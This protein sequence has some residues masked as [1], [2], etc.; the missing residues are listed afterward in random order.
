MSAILKEKIAVLLSAYNGEM[1]IKEQL[2]SILK[3]KL[4]NVD[5][6]VYIRDDGSKD[7]T[8][9]ILRDY[10][11][12]NKNVHLI[13]GNNVGYVGSFLSLI[14]LMIENP[15]VYEYYAFSDQ[16]D[17]WDEDKL[18]VAI[19]SIKKTCSCKPVLY[20]A[21]SRIVNE[22]L[23]FVRNSK[24]PKRKI[25]F[26]NTAIQTCTAGHTYVFNRELLKKVSPKLDDNKIYGHD[27]YF[28]NIA[29]IYGDII[30]DSQPHASYRQHTNNQL[31]TSCNNIFL[32]A[33]E[34]LRRI[35]KGDSRKYAMQMYHIYNL[36]K[37]D[38][39]ELE[40]YEMEQFFRGQKSIFTRLIYAFK[41][42]LYRQDRVENIAFKILY[43]WGGYNI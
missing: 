5:L 12:K 35:K 1:Y 13:E 37:I 42:R 11:R 6:Q 7:K 38:L 36:H 2:D 4:Q 14:K 10:C 26:F 19:N 8:V 20:S 31:G 29:A 15:E 39:S 22:N 41:T 33:K 43:I 9:F 40:C 30:V 21:V 25:T 24:F 34:R 28:T 32:W 23:A 18:Q 17:Y 16:D 3:Q 27:S